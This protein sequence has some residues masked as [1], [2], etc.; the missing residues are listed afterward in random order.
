DVKD[1]PKA[2]AIDA[3]VT[4]WMRAWHLDRASWPHAAAELEAITA[5]FYDFAKAPSP[6]TDRRIRDT[7]AALKRVIDTPDMTLEDHM[8]WRSHCAHGWWGHVRPA[9]ETLRRAEAPGPDAPFWTL[10]C[11]PECL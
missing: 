10:G 5:A 8:A 1:Q 3:V 2:A 6:E 4:E 9:P 11:P 7:H